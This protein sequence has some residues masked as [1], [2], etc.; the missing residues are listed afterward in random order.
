V[1]RPAANPISRC[2]FKEIG[3]Q[4]PR[5]F[6]AIQMVVQ[7]ARVQ[8]LW[9]RPKRIAVTFTLGRTCLIADKMLGFKSS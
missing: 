5:E 1:E 2:R 6:V 4:I 7:L 9:P 8:I 3:C